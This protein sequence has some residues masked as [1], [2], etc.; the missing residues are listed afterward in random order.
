MALGLAKTAEAQRGEGGQRAPAA[1]LEQSAG[2]GL[3]RDLGLYGS[4]VRSALVE[5]A[6]LD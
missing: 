4:D 2:L 6:V 3:E 1:P 5:K